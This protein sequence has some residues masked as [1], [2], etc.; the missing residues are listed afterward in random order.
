VPKQI[1]V[2]ANNVLAF[3]SVRNDYDRVKQDQKTMISG[4]VES[5]LEG[6]NRRNLKFINLNLH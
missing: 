5:R 2:K 6:V 1:F 4:I 3:K